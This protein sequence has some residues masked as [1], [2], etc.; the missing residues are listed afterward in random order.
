MYHEEQKQQYGFPNGLK[1]FCWCV[2]T[3]DNNKELEKKKKKKLSE[4]NLNFQ[5]C[6]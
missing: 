3:N 2:V 4:T 6:T 1:T 5:I